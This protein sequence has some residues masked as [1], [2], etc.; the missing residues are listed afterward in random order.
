MDIGNVT[1]WNILFKIEQTDNNYKLYRTNIV[2]GL[3]NLRNQCSIL[4]R[5]SPSKFILLSNVFLWMIWIFV[6]VQTVC[7]LYSNRNLPN[8]WV[9]ERWRP[10]VNMWKLE[11][12][13]REPNAPPSS[14]RALYTAANWTRG[15]SQNHH[16]R[17]SVMV[18]KKV[19]INQ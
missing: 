16:H 3:R 11:R 1:W 14:G 10:E 6:V 8:K 4:W 12:F 15:V 17:Q 18:L 13:R 19:S 7:T 9:P 5:T 2:A